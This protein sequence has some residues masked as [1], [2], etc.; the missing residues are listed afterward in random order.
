M[1]TYAD[2]F[3]LCFPQEGQ[4]RRAG[5]RGRGRGRGRDEHSEFSNLGLEQSPNTS[6]PTDTRGS[7]NL[8][9]SEAGT[10]STKSDVSSSIVPLEYSLTL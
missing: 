7:R 4:P 10:V 8:G 3:D 6:L 9:M 5:E 1:L 2:V